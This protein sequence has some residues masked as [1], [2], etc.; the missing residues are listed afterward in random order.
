MRNGTTPM[1]HPTGGSL[2]GTDRFI[3]FLIPYL[4]HHSERGTVALHEPFIWAPQLVWL[5]CV[6]LFRLPKWVSVC[7]GVSEKQGDPQDKAQSMLG[8]GQKI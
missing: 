6:V 7:R 4:S 3:P 8:F 1:N 5:G 2:K